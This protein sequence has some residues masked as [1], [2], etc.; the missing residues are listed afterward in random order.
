MTR[1]TILLVLLALAAGFYIGYNPVTRQKAT[2]AWQE[3]R[4]FFVGLGARFTSSI[5][6]MSAKV[7]GVASNGQA[8]P[9]DSPS[10]MNGGKS[11]NVE[12]QPGDS[13]DIS[14]LWRGLRGIW[15]ELTAR[16]KTSG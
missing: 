8:A 6:T 13:F 3:T 10:H 14:T 16:L 1:T 12:S 9:S 15:L 5:E 2:Q 11:G 4:T 7:Q